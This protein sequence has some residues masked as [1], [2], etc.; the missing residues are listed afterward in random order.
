M[1]SSALILFAVPAFIVLMLLESWAGRHGWRA[2][3]AGRDTTASLTMGIGSVVI[4]GLTGGVIAAVFLAAHRFA[5]FDFG[6]AW[7]A[8]VLCFFAEDLAYY[9][10]HRVSHERR[11][12]W[13][14]H[15]VHHSSQRYNLST[16]LRQTWT[17]KLTLGFVFWLPLV[18]IG[19]APGMVALFTATSLL[20]EVRSTVD[21][22]LVDAY[23]DELLGYEIGRAHV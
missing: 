6:Y 2:R 20:P 16:A 14:S 8:F 13:A 17:G 19:F 23:H 22:A 18:L 11:W 1:E 5:I 12:F 3:Y 10:F 21:H 15:V 7:W 9:L 4:N